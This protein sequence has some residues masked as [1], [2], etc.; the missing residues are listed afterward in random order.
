M[1]KVIAVVSAGSSIRA[2][3][4]LRFSIDKSGI[5]DYSTHSGFPPGWE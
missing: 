1:R 5:L 4:I 2:K 3:H